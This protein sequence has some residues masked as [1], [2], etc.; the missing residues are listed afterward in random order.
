MRRAITATILLVAVAVA[1]C[2]GDTEE[3]SGQGIG[4]GA[5]GGE[6]AGG[7]GGGGGLT[8]GLPTAQT[9]FANVDVVVAQEQGFFKEQG[10][11]VQVQN[12]GSGLKSVQAVVAGGVEIGGASIEP[13]AAAVA[14]NQDLKVIGAYADRLTVN[15]T[16]PK[17]IAGVEDLEGKPVGI[18]DVGAFREIM[19][20][21][22]LDRNGMKPDDV[23]YRPVSA[24]GYTGALLA[25]Q[26]DAA[27]LQQEQYFGILAED[28]SYHAIADLYELQP[29]YFY[30]TYFAKSD[31]LESNPNEA[32]AFVRAI[33]QA[34]RFMYE[35]KAETVAIAAETVGFDR[36]AVAKAY[37][38]LLGKNQVFPVDGG[39]DRKRIDYTLGQLGELGTVSGEPPDYSELVDESAASAAEAELGEAER[40][41]GS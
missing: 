24:S 22:L 25:G 32:K 20:R 26:I 8:I 21:Y 41:G 19:V 6:A 39:L 5:Q 11:D 40:G 28:P 16:V 15:V 18:Q 34:H 3:R 9:S 17:S 2:G 12:F 13:V 29:D 31:W 38:V 27:V 10:I 23:D 37:D 7:D 36:K 1:G 14:Q 33:T 35:N 30:G 4:Q